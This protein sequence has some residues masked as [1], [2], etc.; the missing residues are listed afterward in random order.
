MLRKITG[1]NNGIRL[2]S[3][4]FDTSQVG[5]IVW[6][7]NFDNPDNIPQCWNKLKGSLNYIHFKLLLT[8]HL[9]RISRMTENTQYI[10]I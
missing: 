4:A 6:A 5:L 9:L 2:L 10:N 1:P 8:T 3:P 7:H